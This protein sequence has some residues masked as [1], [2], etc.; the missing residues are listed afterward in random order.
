M[1]KEKNKEKEKNNKNYERFVAT[2]EQ[3]IKKNNHSKEWLYKSYGIVTLE[4][5]NIKNLSRTRPRKKMWEEFIW[6]IF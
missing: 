4:L 5:A 2:K 1:I 6:E 3:L